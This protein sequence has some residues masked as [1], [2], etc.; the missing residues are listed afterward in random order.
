MTKSYPKMKMSFI[1]VSTLYKTPKR[2]EYRLWSNILEIHCTLNQF[3]FFFLFFFFFFFCFLSI[4]N[5]YNYHHPKY[6][7]R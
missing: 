6:K 5:N 1:K 4:N 3:S 2:K 7:V